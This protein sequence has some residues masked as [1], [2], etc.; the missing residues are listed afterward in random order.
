MELDTDGLK[1]LIA[2]WT[3]SWNSNGG[4]EPLGIVIRPGRLGIGAVDKRN[5][6]I[7]NSSK[8]IK[9]SL[10]VQCRKRDLTVHRKSLDELEDQD[11]K[12]SVGSKLKGGNALHGLTKKRRRK[13]NK[14]KTECT[15][16]VPILERVNHRL[17]SSKAGQCTPETMQYNRTQRTACNWKHTT[18][19][20]STDEL[21]QKF[22]GATKQDAMVN[23]NVETAKKKWRQCSCLVLSYRHPLRWKCVWCRRIKMGCI[24][25]Q[26]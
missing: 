23:L 12:Y 24:A 13:E 6:A 22:F 25:H 26:V 16:D 7:D 17:Q 15:D 9:R 5:P 3:Q 19:K 10:K 20:L 14:K 8:A 18:D 21:S 1:S 11:S 2:K 4:T